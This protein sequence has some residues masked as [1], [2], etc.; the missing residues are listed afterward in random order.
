MK[1]SQI[2]LKTLRENPA[3]AEME[4][5]RLLVRSGMIKKLA[6]GIFSYGF[7]L[8][9]SIRKFEG[10]L[11]EELGKAGCHEILMPMVQPA[12]LWQLSG[13]WPHMTELLKFK[14]KNQHDFCL[15]ATH[16]EVIVDFVK[17]DLQSYRDL[18][19][20]IY[21]IQTKYRDE[22]RPRF[23]LMRGR[24]F[25]MKDAYSF[26]ANKDGALQSYE[27][28]RK[29]YMEIF[30]RLGVEFT[31]VQAD[32][33][34]IGGDLSH[35]F[36]VVADHGM[37]HVLLCNDCGYSANT[38][39]APVV[40]KKQGTESW[41][42]APM[43][44]FS[45]PG[46]RSIEDLAKALKLDANQLVKTF[47]VKYQN[48]Q[49]DW[50]D[51]TLLL[52]G[53]R[54]VNLIKVKTILGAVAEVEPLSDAEVKKLT[55]AAS[56]SCGPVGITTQVVMDPLLNQ[57]ESFVVGA[58]EDDFHLKNVVPGRDF[59]VTLDA[60]ISQATAGDDCPQC[61]KPLTE[62]RGIEVGHIF[63]LGTKYAE[64]MGLQFLDENGKSQTVEMGC[65]GI[66]VTRSL[67]A[68]VEQSHDEDGMMWPKSVA[69]FSVHVCLLD[70]EDSELS[71]WTEKLVK[72]L[73]SSGVDVFVD[74][75]AERPGIKF[76]DADLLGFPLRVVVGK[77]GMDKGEI[78]VFERKKKQKHVVPA[79]RVYNQCL[80]LLE[81]CF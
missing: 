15:G 20:N 22:I 36:Q 40:T 72:D 50:M 29:A 3:D 74:D 28:M 24:E 19:T 54:E 46:L 34:A 7:L 43:E 26:D 75:R 14:N 11:R 12:S 18:P 78:E 56:G 23:G 25:I 2:T 57:L 73:E 21:Q 38:E 13:R 8:L 6:P 52:P 53:S 10:I 71:Q 17:N 41:S 55:G 68:I 64:P 27:G 33:G 48:A 63:Y 47:F 70:P 9:R 31:V 60:D 59:Q 42:E 37:D 69:P 30:N 62:K 65:Y 39:V 76:K 44:K 67:Q 35:E 1:W 66:G 32:S 81:L 4:S 79:D 61:G 51:A 16:E 77:R 45:T 80:S 49:G 5:H 58:N